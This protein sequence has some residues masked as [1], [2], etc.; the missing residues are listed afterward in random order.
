[1]NGKVKRQTIYFK[2]WTSTLQGKHN[3]K[4]EKKTNCV[5][6]PSSLPASADSKFARKARGNRVEPEGNGYDDVQADQDDTL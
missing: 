1:M 6:R 3:P 4:V 2:E 5:E